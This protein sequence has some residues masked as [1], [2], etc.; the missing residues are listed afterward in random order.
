MFESF[1]RPM[2]VIELVVKE[3][4]VVVGPRERIAGVFDFVRQQFA[5]LESFDPDDISFAAVCIR[6]VRE[7][8]VIRADAQ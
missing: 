5:C 7:Q 4:L 8:F 6:R 2:G 1:V 3:S